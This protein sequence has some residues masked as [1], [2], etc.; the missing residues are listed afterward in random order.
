MPEV[1]RR[2]VLDA[3]RGLV[4]WTVG[5]VL[6]V[7]VTVSIWPSIEGNADL[8]EAIE[9]YPEELKAFL[10]GSLDFATAAGY[11]NAELYSLMV[12]LLLLVYGIGAGARAIAGE[13]E[14]GTLDLLLSHPLRRRRVLLEKLGAAVALLIVLGA[15]VFV[16]VT[17]SSAAF[18]L[19][20]G[21]LDVA[22]A[23]LAAVLLGA[24]FAALAI[25]VGAATGSRA[26]AIAVPTAV[27][28]ASYL[29]FGLG[30]LVDA[31]EPL[32]PLSPWEWYAGGDP[33]RNGFDWAGT[34]LLAAATAV[35]AGAAIPLFERRDLST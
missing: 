30:N 28:I 10:G 2:S 4:F 35:L 1:L 18:G 16:S 13:E 20:V 11:L 5:I 21:T 8:T 17:L 3:L 22:A 29:L 23:T 31:L 14:A 34:L 7:L 9:N 12:P 24:T 26:L 33:L 6:L 25:L 15:I 27:V 32:R 19:D